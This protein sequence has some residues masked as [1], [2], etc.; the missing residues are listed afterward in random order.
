MSEFSAVCFSR[1]DAHRAAETAYDHAKTMIAG[2]VNAEIICR[3]ATKPISVKLRGLFHGAVL[4][5]ISEQAKVAGIRYVADVWKEHFRKEFLPD[6]FVRVKAIRRGEDGHPEPYW[7]SRR[8]RSS[9][10]DLGNRRYA[11]HVDQVIAYAV[12]ELGVEFAFTN[13]ER[14]LLTH[15]PRRK[16]DVSE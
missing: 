11:E 7:T 8:I 1:E 4:T 2:G 3:P 10:E 13:E 5:Q 14:T 15:K 16:P 9:T 6:Q 12:T